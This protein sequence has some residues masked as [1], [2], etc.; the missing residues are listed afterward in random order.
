MRRNKNTVWAILDAATKEGGTPTLASVRRYV[1]ETTG[2]G[3]A[4]QSYHLDLLE[5]AGFIRYPP[6]GTASW[7]N[8][9]NPTVMLT[10]QGWDL[11]ES[12]EKEREAR[13]TL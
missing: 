4:E 12:I 2:A 6:E 8:E 5:H 11:L 3:N 10:W 13:P 9:Q 7:D 1:A